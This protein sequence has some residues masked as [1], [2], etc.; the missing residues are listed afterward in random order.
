MSTEKIK[1]GGRTIEISRADKVLFPPDLTKLDLARYYERVAPVMLPHLKDRPLNLERYP[2]G[3][4]GH[5]IVQQHASQH[6]PA[7]IRRATVAKKGGQVE[8]VMAGDAA[9]LVYL[10]NQACI[11]LHRWPSRADRLDRPDRMIFDLDPSRH[12]PAE[13]RRAAQKIVSLLQELGCQPWVMTSG[14]RGYHIVLPLQRRTG[15]EFVRTFARDVAELARRREPQM[16]TTEQRKAKREQKI[17]IDVMRNGYAHTSVAPYAV[18]A[19]PKAPVATPL[20]LPELAARST[21]PD[22]WTMQLVLQRLEGDGDPWADMAKQAVTLTRARLA[23]DDALT[24]A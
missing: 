22:R 2:D 20:H 24:A 17:L 5:R 8:H 18:R 14:S 1:A 10:A 12:D 15:F 3:I 13:V 9:T 21:R 19:R 23:L 11:T 7:W 16:F 4:D 6:F